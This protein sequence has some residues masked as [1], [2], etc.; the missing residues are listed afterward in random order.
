MY[1]EYTN[2]PIETDIIK[3]ETNENSTF[4]LKNHNS[5]GTTIKP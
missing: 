2:N 3:L 1:H 4:I 5:S